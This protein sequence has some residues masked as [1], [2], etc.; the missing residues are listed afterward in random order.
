MPFVIGG[1][2]G[3]IA[4]AVGTFVAAKKGW[5]KQAA[6]AVAGAAKNISEKAGKV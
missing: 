6:D 3:L 2:V 1:F 5:I 4:G